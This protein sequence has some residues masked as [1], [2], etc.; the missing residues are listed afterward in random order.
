MVIFQDNFTSIFAYDKSFDENVKEKLINILKSKLNISNY[1]KL[2]NETEKSFFINFIKN[3]YK[4]S[5]Y[6][7]LHEPKLTFGDFFNQKDI[8]YF[9]FNKNE[10][11]NIEGFSHDLKPCAII[12]PFPILRKNYSYMGIKPAVYCLPEEAITEDI[13]QICE[14]NKKPK[15]N[16]YNS[17]NNLSYESSEILNQNNL[18]SQM[19]FTPLKMDDNFNIETS[20]KLLDKRFKESFKEK[21]NLNMNLTDKKVIHSKT[22]SFQSSISQI[23]KSGKSSPNYY[24]LNEKKENDSFVLNL[25]QEA[26]NL[27]KIIK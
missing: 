17:S 6:M 3:L 27:S 16:R 4:L 20:K 11:M 22:P 7:C 18:K 9:Y 15:T 21:R 8:D 2:K 1:E 25:R 13:K 23:H 26:E 10:F 19:Q 12:L 5:M 24:Q 14:N